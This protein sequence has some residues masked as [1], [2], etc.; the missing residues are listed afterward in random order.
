MPKRLWLNGREMLRKNLALTWVLLQLTWGKNDQNPDYEIIY[1]NEQN[2]TVSHRK[3]MN[4]FSGI[5]FVEQRVLDAF[6]LK[7]NI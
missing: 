7:Q 2:I 1:F 4:G 5:T 6:D 3:T